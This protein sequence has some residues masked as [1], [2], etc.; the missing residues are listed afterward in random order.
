MKYTLRIALCF[1][2][3][4]VAFTARSAEPEAPPVN[5]E[6]AL[7]CRI[8]APVYTGFALT[9]DDSDGGYGYRA[10]GWTKQKS[11]TAMLSQYHLPKPVTVGS[12]VSSTLVFSA[13]GLAAVLD[14][15]DT[16]AVAKALG[17]KNTLL[18]HAEA[19]AALGLTPEQ[20][21]QIP[22]NPAFKGEAVMIDKTEKDPQFGKIHTRIVR[23]VDN[24]PAFPGKTLVG[25][26]YSME[27]R[28]I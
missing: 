24:N 21:N 15:P 7:A 8:D 4:L 11:P 3:A 6:D 17:V 28:D 26:S 18:T 23:H 19:A 22:V 25:C 5:V 14:Q 10:R 20:A 13:S 2:A 16:V 27:F 12:F 9:L 1:C